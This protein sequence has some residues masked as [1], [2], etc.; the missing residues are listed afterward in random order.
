MMSLY[1]KPHRSV[2]KPNENINQIK[3]IIL[4]MNSD[5]LKTG[6]KNKNKMTGFCDIAA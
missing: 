3:L 2:F 5:F 6:Q 4:S 1:R